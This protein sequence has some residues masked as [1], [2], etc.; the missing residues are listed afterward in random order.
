MQNGIG[1]VPNGIEPIFYTY[2]TLLIYNASSFS[3]CVSKVT[4]GVICVRFFCFIFVLFA[5]VST[6]KCEPHAQEM[7]VLTAFTYIIHR[8]RRNW[9][10]IPASKK[11]DI[12]L[13]K[14]A[15]MVNKILTI[16]AHHHRNCCSILLALWK[17]N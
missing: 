11:W 16:S 12:G 10:L 7:I 5:T 9:L 8:S 3:W 15:A 14:Q 13:C 6:K 17:E 4:N 2:R 1:I